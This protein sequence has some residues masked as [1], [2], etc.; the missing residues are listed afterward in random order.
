[1][2]SNRRGRR[3]RGRNGRM[4]RESAIAPHPQ[5]LQQPVKKMNFGKG[6]VLTSPQLQTEK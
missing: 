6:E 5:Q 1:M 4:G 2:D 3:G